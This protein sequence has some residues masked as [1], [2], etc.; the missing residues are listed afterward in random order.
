MQ[1]NIM[2]AKSH[3]VPEDMVMDIF[4][5][6]FS[7]DI[8]FQVEGINELERTLLIRTSINAKLSHHK[9]ALENVNSLLLDFKYYRHESESGNSHNNNPDDVYN[10]M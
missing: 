8:P 3:T 6:L 7:N 2:Q 5:I 4:S 10:N 9:K 1:Q